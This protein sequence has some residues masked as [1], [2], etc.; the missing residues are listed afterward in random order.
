[1]PACAGMTNR[2][3]MSQNCNRNPVA[4]VTWF[5]YSRVSVGKQASQQV[6][7]YDNFKSKGTSRADH[8]DI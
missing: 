3:E 6:S 8:K 5:N 2:R 4:F 7:Y 1:M